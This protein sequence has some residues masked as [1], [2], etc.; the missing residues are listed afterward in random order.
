MS[1]MESG[2]QRL[3]LRGL[4]YMAVCDIISGTVK[5]HQRIILEM[6]NETLR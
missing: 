2:S 6:G 1:S 3:I 5:Y 4:S